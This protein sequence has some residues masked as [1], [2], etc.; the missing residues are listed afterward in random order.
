MSELNREQIIKDLECSVAGDCY[1]CPYA[2]IGA[3]CRD[4]MCEDAL[5]LIKELT[6][7]VERLRKQCGEA[8]VECDER[9]AE[10]LK[11]VAELTKEVEQRIED[12]QENQRKWET[13]YDELTE[14]NER[15][16]ARVLEEN[17]L[18]HQAEEMLAQGMTVVKS[19][20][21]RKMK[22][23][24]MQKIL[25]NNVG[26]DSFAYFLKGYIDQIAKEMLEGMEC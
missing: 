9:D 22:E 8:I 26:N 17:H 18:R 14:E 2:E 24:L 12:Y 5:A 11:Q 7:D 23:R 16:K 20:T 21:V 10:R 4:R 15:L 19:D 13:A 6:E 25:E 3:G 1:P